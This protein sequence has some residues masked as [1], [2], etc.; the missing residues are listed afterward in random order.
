MTNALCLREFGC[1]RGEEAILSTSSIAFPSKGLVAIEGLTQRQST[2]LARL[3]GRFDLPELMWWGSA[4]YGA[5]DYRVCP[6]AALVS[7]E[8]YDHV[9]TVEDELRRAIPPRLLLDGRGERLFRTA[10]EKFA[11]TPLVHRSLA[12]LAAMECFRTRV[13]V[14]WLREA[15]AMFVTE[16]RVDE[17]ATTT[18]AKQ[19]DEHLVVL[20]P[21]VRVE[22]P[23][24]VLS[25]TEVAVPIELPW[26]RW[27]DWGRIGGM[28][29]PGRMR[30]TA[31]VA[32]GLVK[33]GVTLVVGLEESPL[34][35]RGTLE[36]EGIA[37]RHFPIPDMH[38]PPDRDAAIALAQEV[39][40]RIE[41]HGG[42]VFHCKAGLGRTGTMLGL[43]LMAQGYRYPQAMTL[44]RTL[45]SQLVQ[46]EE[47]RAFLREAE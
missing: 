39:V 4:R 30:S 38:C 22:M 31:E 37:Y 29:R 18:V 21:A 7:D 13:A 47:Q 28:A 2:T 42:V 16:L 1:R 32:A 33:T 11:L 26:M 44:L 35:D 43:C 25:W 24:S 34:E 23:R 15:P 17:D 41:R 9:A 46:T 8:P 45:H 36:A 12:S 14:G 3:L 6:A 20:A 40:D 27:I 19:A 10:L 5:L